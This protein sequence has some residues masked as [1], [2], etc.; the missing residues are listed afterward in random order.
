MI[1]RN[2]TQTGFTLIELL[3]VIVIIGILVGLG[4]PQL[5]K[6]RIKAKETESVAGM[7]KVQ[8]AL[9]EFAVDHNGF[10]PYRILYYAGAGNTTPAE[11]SRAQDWPPMGII[12]GVKV[13]DENMN[14]YTASQVQMDPR[15]PQD[16]RLMPQPRLGSLSSFFNQYSDPLI[17]LGYLPTGYPKNPFFKRQIGVINWAWSEG[18]MYTPASQVV[19]SDGDIVYT[20]FGVWNAATSTYDE[21]QGVL[22]DK[23]RYPVETGGGILAGEWGLDLV[24]SYQLWVYGNLPV[25]NGYKSAYDNSEFPGPPPRKVPVR[26]DWNGNGKKDPFEAGIISYTSGGAG[27]GSRDQSTGGKV[28]F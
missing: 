26:E 17:A 9:E 7:K 21:P 3:V 18:E 8:T 20:H 11:E 5:M 13:V 2:R 15:L 27:A 19:V 6:A 10:Y 22:R 1:N 28:E 4:L 23:V 12:G 24:D 16:A 25:V 14:F